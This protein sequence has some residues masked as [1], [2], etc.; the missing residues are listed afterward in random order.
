MTWVSHQT[1]GLDAWK[2]LEITLSVFNSWKNKFVRTNAQN[3]I[4]I[5]YSRESSSQN[6]VMKSDKVEITTEKQ[7]I[8][9]KSDTDE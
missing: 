5:S 1:D 6:F 9:Q 4:K 7:N 8:S 3:V 2:R